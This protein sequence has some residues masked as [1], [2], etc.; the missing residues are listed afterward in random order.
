MLPTE[1]SS[2]CVSDLEEVTPDQKHGFK[3]FP[4]K[5]LSLSAVAETFD[6][7]P[8]E[9]S[10]AYC[11]WSSLPIHAAWVS[12]HQASLR[13]T[14]SAFFEQHGFPMRPAN[15]VKEVTSQLQPDER[16]AK[17]RKKSQASSGEV[18]LSKMPDLSARPVGAHALQWEGSDG[19]LFSSKNA[20][21]VLCRRISASGTNVI[22]TFGEVL[23]GTC[24][25]VNKQVPCLGQAENA[26]HYRRRY[27]SLQGSKS[28]LRYF[29]T[30]RCGS[31]FCGP[32]GSIQTEF[33][34][35]PSKLGAHADADSENE[36]G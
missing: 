32:T 20:T 22:N 6:M 14:A 21:C 8:L 4:D 18:A 33:I 11:Q 3:F 23:P 13:S 5:A 28:W 24:F 34:I 16:K 7:N 29:A 31:S 2:S 26:E 15:L 27:F 9:F 25:A 12:S 10:V 17:Q 1:W 35:D 19:K 30:C 36:W